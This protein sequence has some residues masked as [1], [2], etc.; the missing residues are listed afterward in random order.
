M[1]T[2][3]RLSASPS[4]A[5]PMSMDARYGAGLDRTLVFGGGGVWFVAWQTGYLRMLMKLGLD[6]SL[7]ER[8]VGTSAGSVMASIV[9]GRRL[10]AFHTAMAGLSRAP[11]VVG[12]LAPAGSLGPSQDRALEMFRA[13][14]DAHPDTI[15]AIGFAALAADTPSA[16]TLK[17]NL[18]VLLAMRRWPSPT[19]H[20]TCVDTYTAERCIIT[21]DARVSLPRAVAASSAVPGLFPPQPILDRRC[22]DGGVSG[23]GTHVDLVAGARRAIVI[24]LTDGQATN[25]TWGTV[26][27]GGIAAQFTALRDSGTAV[28]LCVPRGPIPEDLMNPRDIADAMARGAAQAIEDH[29]ELARSW[30]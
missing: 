23:T 19:L 24:S 3:D 1:S 15:K 12:A 8:V 17:R 26:A 22:M 21:A 5:V 30:G 7:A 29:P 11:Q 13:A 4:L 2:D 25:D 6:L 20:I 14:T 18:T 16:S 28:N 9:T 27:P 10:A